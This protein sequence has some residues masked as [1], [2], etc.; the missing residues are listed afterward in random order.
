MMSR[1]LYPLVALFISFHAHAQEHHSKADL[2]IERVTASQYKVGLYLELEKDWHT[3]WLNPG[4]TGMAPKIKYTLDFPY[5]ASNMIAPAPI[6]ITSPTAIT[7]GFENEVLFYQHVTIDHDQPVRLVVETEWLVC[8]DICIPNTKTFDVML[9]SKTP[10]NN[11]MFKQF[12]FPE[13]DAFTEF[14]II[15]D[16][17]L[18]VSTSTFKG[19]QWD[20]FPFGE[21][22][23]HY[24]AMQT[25]I[26]NGKIVFSFSKPLNL[27]TTQF[28]LV[29]YENNHP[30]Q[31]QWLSNTP[32][33]HTN[34]SNVAS[35]SM[36][37]VLIFAFLGGILLNA[38]PCVFPVI[39]IKFFKLTEI[40][41]KEK[42]AIIRSNLLY[43][44]G[45]VFSFLVLA[46]GLVL[47]QKLGH[48]VGWGFQLQSPVSV[49]L[50]IFLF[51]IIG[52]NL[53]G[54]FQIKQF[55]LPRFAQKLLSRF[56]DLGDFV[57]GVFTTIVASPCTA[58]FMAAS[59]GYA[60][61]QNP[62]YIFLTFTFLG[63]GLAFPYIV[64]SIFPSLASKLPRPGKWMDRVKEALALPMFLTCAWLIWVFTNL[65]SSLSLL[66]L[67]VGLVLLEFS[68]RMGKWSKSKWPGILI[69]TLACWVALF[70]HFKDK[71]VVIDWQSFSPELV[72]SL[73][74]EGNLVFV[75]FTADW[76]LTCKANE[77][78]T[79]TNNRV[80]DAINQNQVQML[81]ADWTK[82]DDQITA[83]LQQ[84]GRVGVPFYL[85]YKPG[86]LNP[87]ILP[88][89]LTPSIF[90]KALEP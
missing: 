76:C 22:G 66:Y 13:M 56:D 10:K 4:D 87:E 55:P 67:L 78:L 84:Y 28:L 41:T 33:L 12:T 62:F 52:L 71:K 49:A 54:I 34:A 44:F 39:S 20:L 25:Q 51:Y 5:Q 27:E 79:F 30:V 42:H 9:D 23:Y 6:R 37:M 36:I 64:F 85:L 43:T 81:K 1:F 8:K 31:A 19:Q 69:F 68:F 47:L 82:K 11:P 17:N 88:T 35:M 89:L 40:S 46:F 16:K 15:S 24:H 90:L 72:S 65:T 32:S 74:Q 7:F 75:D 61:T 60:L 26:Q 58:P 48:Q 59:I 63:L 45:V 57:T 70:P 53:L 38:M 73:H 77:A 83:I 21:D 29:G 86:Q 3:Y 18:E 80:I 50:M 14:S 2:I